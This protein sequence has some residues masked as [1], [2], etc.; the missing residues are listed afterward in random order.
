MRAAPGPDC[1]QPERR[2]S[3]ANS[4]RTG[5]SSRLEEL[6]ENTVVRPREDCTLCIHNRSGCFTPQTFAS[7]AALWCNPNN[8]R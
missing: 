6:I 7:A 1:A 4:G 8:F 5:D 3:Q 2:A